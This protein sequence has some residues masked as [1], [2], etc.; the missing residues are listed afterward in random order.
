MALAGLWGTPLT[1]P[2][3]A[4]HIPLDICK[5]KGQLGQHGGVCPDRGAPTSPF[6]PAQN[7]VQRR[8]HISQGA[9]QQ[10]HWGGARS[11]QAVGAVLVCVVTTCRNDSQVREGP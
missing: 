5:L 9:T 2:E 3:A 10:H 11:L 1:I 8:W 6:W 4:G 7:K